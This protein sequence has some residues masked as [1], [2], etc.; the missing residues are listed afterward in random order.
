[1]DRFFNC[2]FSE[3]LFH[4][5][6][7]ENHP[8]AQCFCAEHATHLLVLRTVLVL[9]TLKTLRELEQLLCGIF[10]LSCDI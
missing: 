10:V 1:M 6:G 3:V 8:F 7:E 9:K 2:E 5:T 4:S